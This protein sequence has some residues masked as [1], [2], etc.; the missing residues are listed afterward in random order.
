MENWNNMENN[1]LFEDSNQK[2][3]SNF[4]SYLKYDYNENSNSTYPKIST[5][6]TIK[7]KINETNFID[8]FQFESKIIN[9]K[10]EKEPSFN[11]VTNIE[12]QSEEEPYEFDSII[13]YEYNCL[14]YLEKLNYLINNYEKQFI[15]NIKNQ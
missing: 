9:E 4:S 14:T 11:D 12:N 6:K 10:E 1:S 2:K 3:F 7:I 15:K 13:N 8:D 5:N